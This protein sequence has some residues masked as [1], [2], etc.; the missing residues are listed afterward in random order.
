MTDTEN[1]VTIDARVI[2]INRT[3]NYLIAEGHQPSIARIEEVYLY[4]KNQH[5][6]CCEFTPSYYLIHLYTR[7]NFT[8]VGNEL[9]DHE[10]NEIFEAYE[11]E[12]T[13]N[14]YIHCHEID[15]LEAKAKPFTYHTHG[16]PEFGDAED[17][18]ETK[19]AFHDAVMEALREHFQAN[20]PI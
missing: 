14:C 2:A 20:C 10:Q 8:P 17:E 5:T 18:F 7:V 9:S 6:H 3:H 12:D 16:D 15:A 4:D 1:Q 13:D 11:H 19:E